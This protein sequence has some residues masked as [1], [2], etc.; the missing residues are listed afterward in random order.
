MIKTTLIYEAGCYGEFT[1]NL[2]NL[3]DI[4]PGTRYNAHT[5]TPTYT[6]DFLTNHHLVKEHEVSGH[7]TKITFENKHVDL[8]NRNKWTK[9]TGGMEHFTSQSFPEHTNK[10]ILAIAIGKINMLNENNH[11]KSMENK[12]NLEL[13]LDNFFLDCEEW[14]LSFGN[15]LDVLKIPHQPQY[16]RKCY[17]TFMISQEKILN[18]KSND[19]IGLG[20]LLG[21]FYFERYG[22]DVNQVRLEKMLELL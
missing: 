19:E 13:K 3:Q 9:V 15:M 2:L 1:F 17:D 10:S 5:F 11:F 21:Q 20:N 12:D 16:L 4:K 22:T 14:I 8:I 6:G 7:I 18:S